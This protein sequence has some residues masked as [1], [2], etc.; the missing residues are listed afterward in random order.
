MVNMRISED[1]VTVSEFKAQ[2]SDWMRRIG[3]R[4]H[5]LVI[6]QNGKPAGVLLSPAA[7]DELFEHQQFL[8]AVQEGLEDEKAGRIHTT[9]EVFARLEQR[10]AAIE[11]E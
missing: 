8:K 3:E 4:R 2:A 10:L 7:F 1:I 11:N 9:E 6:T 5:P